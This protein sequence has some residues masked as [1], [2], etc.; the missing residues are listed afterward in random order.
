MS[1]RPPGHPALRARLA[2]ALGSL[3]L[4]HSAREV[5]R[6]IGRKGDTVADRGDDVD[7][8]PLSELLLVSQHSDEIADALRVYVVGE[9][10]ERGEAIAAPAAL[11]AEI[12]AGARI[13][14]AAA[15]ALGDGRV[16]KDEANALLEAIAARRRA[17]DQTLLPSLR[18]VVMP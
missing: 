14:Q 12:A 4:D 17:E 16:T 7:A 3:L 8:W 2:E 5:G 11:V 6:W 9:E 18:A 13:A 10:I 1:L 15:A